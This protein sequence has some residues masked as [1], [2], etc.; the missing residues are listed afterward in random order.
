MFSL[1]V[2]NL[3]KAS[4]GSTDSSKLMLYPYK[5]HAGYLCPDIINLI[6][7]RYTTLRIHFKINFG[8]V[9]HTI[10]AC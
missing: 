4:S 5:T 6:D 7:V 2:G 10:E 3:A 8:K 9:W 1:V